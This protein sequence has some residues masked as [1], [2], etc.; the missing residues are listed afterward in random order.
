V[1]VELSGRSVGSASG[2][3]YSRGA[4]TIEHVDVVVT[5]RGWSTG[6]IG[7]YGDPVIKHVTVTMNSGGKN[8]G[9][10]TLSGSPKLT[11]VEVESSGGPS[12]EGIRLRQS[13]ATLINVQSRANGSVGRG[14]G[15]LLTG[16]GN[17]NS[18]LMSVLAA[19]SGP[20]GGYGIVSNAP[21]SFT[22]LDNS[23]VFGTTNAIFVDGGHRMKI[24]S[25]KIARGVNVASGSATCAAVVN[26]RDYTFLPDTCP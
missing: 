18:L 10:E 23:V 22:R 21:D 17:T 3:T 11:D 26:G 6:I 4:P 20:D 19:G 1:R 7:S 16:G 2:L 13:R 9:I 8:I 14:T 24:S 25:S 12:N 5:V 15:I